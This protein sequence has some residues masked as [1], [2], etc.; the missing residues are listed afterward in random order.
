MLAA[1]VLGAVAGFGRRAIPPARH[2]AAMAG[3]ALVGSAPLIWYE[4]R[5][6]GR[7]TLAFMGGYEAVSRGVWHFVRRQYVLST[8]L[9]Y[10]FEHRGG[11]WDGPPLLPL[12]QVAFVW[13]AAW[14]AAAGAM[15][16]RDDDALRRWHRA[17]AVALVALTAVMVFTRLPVRGHHFVNLVPIAAV[18]VVLA[19]V[20]LLH[21]RPA[22]RRAVAAASAIYLGIALY[23]DV[24]AWRGLR[25]VGGT[26]N[27]SD[28]IEAVTRDLDARRAPRVAALDWGLQ[29]PIYV[30]T[31]GRVQARELFWSQ[32]DAAAW[33]EEIAGGGVYL[34]HAAPYRYPLGEAP[35][36]RFWEALHGSGQRFSSVVFR[37]RRGRPHTELIEVQP[38]R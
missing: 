27:W 4:V 30:T 6:G 23:W 13:M 19:A 12:W 8:S 32:T 18:V 24:S 25:R 3:G 11:L 1:A 9:L 20:R 29:N 7:D 15:I 38:S 21:R 33:R 2:L 5:S 28:A 22:W 26:G 17:A 10:D 37:D 36:A 31:S 35:T 16:G 14:T 34:T